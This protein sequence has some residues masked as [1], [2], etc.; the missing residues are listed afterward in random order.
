MMKFNAEYAKDA[1][2]KMRIKDRTLNLLCAL[3]VLCV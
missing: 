2:E 3:R 1:E